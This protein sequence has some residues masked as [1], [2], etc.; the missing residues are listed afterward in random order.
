MKNRK[1]DYF[2]LIVCWLV[3]VT[4]IFAGVG[5]IIN[6][7]HFAEDINNYRM[8]PYLLVTILAVVLPWLEVLCGLFLIIGFWRKG[9]ALILLA[10]SFIFFIAIS[11]AM[12][13]GLDISCGCFA[14]SPEAIKIGY[15]RLVEDFILFG[16]ILMIYLNLLKTPH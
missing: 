7:A 1:W 16:M 13:R 4:F 10:L 8:L 14:V 3:A 9:A 6:P 2:I 5:K 11:S 12:I 15:K